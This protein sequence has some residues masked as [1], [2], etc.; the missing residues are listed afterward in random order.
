PGRAR[1][2]RLATAGL[3]ASIALAGLAATARPADA[4]LQIGLMDPAYASAEPEAYW[5]DV[6]A[7]R[8]AF[9]R[10]DLHWNE[11]APTKPK[12]QRDP[13]D[14]AYK[15]GYFDDVVREA[16]ANGYVGCDLVVTVWRTPGWASSIKGNRNYANMPN[17]QQWRNF[18]AAA[19]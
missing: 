3:A 19:A 2:T 13:A 11:V 16:A 1:R 4:A 8:P 15:W 18:I 12:K 6:K 5:N 10:Y 7:L 9:L 17:L 14:P